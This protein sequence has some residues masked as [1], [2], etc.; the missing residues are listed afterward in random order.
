MW[1]FATDFKLRVQASTPL[2]LATVNRQHTQLVKATAKD[3]KKG[4]LRPFDEVIKD[5]KKLEGLFALYRHKDSGKIY[6]EINPEQLNKNY[7]GIVTMESGIGES[8]IYSGL[9]LSDF[10]FY[11]RRVNNNLQF[12]IRNVKFRTRPGDP[13][14]RSLNRSF[15]DSVLYSLDILSIHPQRKSLLVNLGDLLLSD[16]AGLA[17]MLKESLA[18]AYKLDEN[19]S[20]FDEAKTFPQNIEIDS[21]FGFSSSNSQEIQALPDSRALTLKVHYSFSQLPESKTYVPRL[22]DD[23]VGYFLATY[24]DF[25]NSNRKDPFVRYIQR[26]HLEKQDAAAA[27]SAPKKPIVFWIENTLPLEYRD[28]VREGALLWNKAFEKAGFK[29]AI[30][31]QQ[32]PNDAK[33]DPSDVRYNTIRWFNSLDAAFALGPRRVN[34]LTGE[35]LDADI[36]VD[37]NLVRSLKQ[38][39]R[40]FVEPNK[41]VSQMKSLCTQASPIP[42]QESLASGKDQKALGQLTEDS[43]AC[44]GV[45]SSQQLAMGSLAMSLLQNDIPSSEEMKEY[46]HQYVRYLIA[47]EVGHT[48]GLRHN[49]HGST[50]LM[51]QDLNNT[52][53]THTKGLVSSV[54]DYVPVNLAPQGVKQGDYFPVVV[55]PYD[56]WAIEYGYKFSGAVV[57]QA[58]LRFLEQIAQRSTQPELAY[59]TDEDIYDFDP[60]ANQ[61]DLSGNVLLYGQWQMDN[62]RA[63]W[64]RLDKRYPL[65]GESYSQ[66]RVL[67]NMV[68]GH[69]FRYATYL[70]DYVGGH[71]FNRNHAGDPGERSPFEPVPP[72]KQREALTKLQKYVFASDAF[73]FPPE[74]LSQLAPSRWRDWSNPNPAT[75]LTYPIHDSILGRQSAILRSLLSSARL[76]SLR[77]IELK[78]PP[79]GALTLPE[80]FE[81]LQNSIW[82]EVLQPGGELQPISSIRRALQREHLNILLEM[83]LRTSAVPEDARTLAW[84]ELRQLRKGLDVAVKRQGKNLDTY[85]KAHLEE[86]R[87]RISKALDAQL[88]SQ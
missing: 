6:L 83:V 39:Y 30:E 55:G 50:L 86:T 41:S 65:R 45:E 19:K 9:P 11:F 32:M 5:T 69:Y 48:L 16:F 72:A 53:I 21:V 2:N 70:T 25:S 51:P 26:W 34:P 64:A 18:T 75:R 20:Y 38:D 59:A 37:A 80:L 15:S 52:E 13:Q 49:F 85:T 82:T 40:A 54:M 78:S 8:G 66:L 88:Q 71:S 22:A 33:W 74:L 24:Q 14:T 28:A 42:S 4:E 56:E 7:L 58:E 84:Y 79:E 27:L 10:L 17:P 73:Q 23:R 31:V 76:K 87:D 46:T 57:P 63:M 35:I 60:G 12:A 77:D 62:A 36:L 68:L 29:N 43:D 61:F 3:S 44:F 47:H 1:I 67:F 81:T